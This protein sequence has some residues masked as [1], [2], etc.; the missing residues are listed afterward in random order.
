M[1]L[2]LSRLVHLQ[3]LD[4]KLHDLEQQ[5]RQIPRRLDSAQ[6]LVDQAQ[7]RLES[8]QRLTDTLTTERRSG[9]QD[10]SE[11]ERHINKIR[12]RLSALKTNKEYQAHLFEIELA[13][14]KKDALEEKILQAMDRAET[15]GKE[16]E[17]VRTLVRDLTRDLEKEKVELESLGTKLT[18]EVAA[19][20]RHKQTLFDTLDKQV[21]QRYAALKSSLKLVVVARVL[22]GTCLGCQLQIPPQLIASVK[23]AEQLLTC[24]HCHR[25]LYAEEARDAAAESSSVPQPS[26]PDMLE[27]PMARERGSH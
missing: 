3:E 16:L 2:Q 17:E 8:L 1:N 5:Q 23:R 14:K 22:D 9:E 19:T 4:L 18:N 6:A 12:E 10:L 27:E 25:I 11:H 15:V 24:P 20:A 13:G 26:A 21:C 7:Q